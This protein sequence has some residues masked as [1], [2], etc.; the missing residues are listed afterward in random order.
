MIIA[1]AISGAL[2]HRLDLEAL[3]L[4]ALFLGS[5]KALGVSSGL[6]FAVVGERAL[7]AMVKRSGYA[8]QFDALCADPHA[9]SYLDRFDRLQRV[10]STNLLRAAIAERQQRD[11]DTPSV[12][13]LL[14]TERALALFSAERAGQ[15][16]AEAIAA[17]HAALAQQARDGVRAL[18]LELMPSA[19]FESDSVTVVLLPP[20]IDASRIRKIVA[21][22]SAIAIAGAQGDYWKPRMLRIGTLGFV[23]RTD[24]ARCLRALRSALAEV[25]YSPDA[26]TSAIGLEIS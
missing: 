13:H 11:V 10:H 16:A 20:G 17:A 24:I 3:D 12:F 15:D 25:G 22:E 5:Q 8:G 1:D 2:A 9:G 7:D 19:P 18:G 23:S 26:R 21:R 6:A 14:S 4:D